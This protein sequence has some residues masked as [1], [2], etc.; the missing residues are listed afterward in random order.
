MIERK[1]IIEF[2]GN[3]VSVNGMDVTLGEK[4]K[5]F[6]VIKQD[7]SEIFLLEATKDKVRIIV[8]V[9]S[10]DTSVCDRETRHFNM[11]A[12]ALGKGITIV[13]ISMDLP[14]AQE[15]WCG[16]AGV[17]QVMVVSDHKYAEFG[18]NYAC[19]MLEPRLLR[20]AIFIVD[21]HNVIRYAKYMPAL[22]V[23]PDYAE[24]LAEAKLLLKD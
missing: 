20:R 23:E 7:W 13:V 19:L 3:Q 8:A 10:L 17:D 6:R 14:F 4:A 12:A 18:E 9:P 24:V 22:N 16:A 2:K 21:K 11:E 1:G 15:R 5:D